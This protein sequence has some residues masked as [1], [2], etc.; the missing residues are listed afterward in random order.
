LFDGERRWRRRFRWF[1]NGGG[2]AVLFG[3]GRPERTV[4]PIGDTFLGHI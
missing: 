3:G 2:E 1:R 4:E